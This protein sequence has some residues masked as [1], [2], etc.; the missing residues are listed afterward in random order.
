LSKP[1]QHLLV[2]F[3]FALNLVGRCEH[4]VTFVT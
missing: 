4:V 2:G 3:S 1:G